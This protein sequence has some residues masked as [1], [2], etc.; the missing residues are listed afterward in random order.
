MPSSRVEVGFPPIERDIKR[1]TGKAELATY[2]ARRL[3]RAI[4]LRLDLEQN[5]TPLPTE[6]GG[7]NEA[8]ASKSSEFF[9]RVLDRIIVNEFG[10][11]TQLESPELTEAIGGKLKTLE[12]D[13][14][15]GS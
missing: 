3:E 7:S 13:L 2:L 14:K 8:E 10:L 15:S 12:Q 9:K 1:I 11:L 5:R 4:S 6:W